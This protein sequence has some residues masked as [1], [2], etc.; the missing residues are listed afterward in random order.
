MRKA[1]ARERAR[2]Q[3]RL[4]KNR[5]AARRGHRLHRHSIYRSAAS[6]FKSTASSALRIV[7]TSGTVLP[8]TLSRYRPP[9][10]TATSP[11]LSAV[12]HDSTPGNPAIVVALV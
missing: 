10:R 9:T 3:E 5:S 12:V 6:F 4:G 1:N 7:S 8:D 2:Y 11:F